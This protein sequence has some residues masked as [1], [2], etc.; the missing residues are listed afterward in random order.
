LAIRELVDN[1]GFQTAIVCDGTIIGAVGYHAVNWSHRSTSIGYWLG[2]QHQGEG[3]M[4][5]AVCLLVDH[6]L[7]TWNLNRVEVRVAPDNRRSRAIPERLGF[8]EEG[9]LR[10]AERVGDRFLDSTVY[11]VLASDWEAL[12]QRLL[13]RA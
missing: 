7:R 2:E 11:G 12:G 8:R 10:Q 5:R 4:T 1:D 6:A 3:T 9:T 13:D